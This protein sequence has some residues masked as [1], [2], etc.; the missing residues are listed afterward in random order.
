MPFFPK[1]SHTGSR[2]LNAPC[3]SDAFP[4]APPTPDLATWNFPLSL[5]AGHGPPYTQIPAQTTTT[6]IHRLQ[7]ISDGTEP[8]TRWARGLPPCPTQAVSL[9][10]EDPEAA[11]GRAGGLCGVVTAAGRI[12]SSPDSMKVCISA[13]LDWPECGEET[14]DLVSRTW[15]PSLTAREFSQIRGRTTLPTAPLA[16]RDT[17]SETL[18]ATCVRTSGKG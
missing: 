4:P 14:D 16:V 10:A 7:G 2:H 8:V 1:D 11:E 17:H 12:C 5:G 3:F 15:C 18:T 9:P 13:T 6:W